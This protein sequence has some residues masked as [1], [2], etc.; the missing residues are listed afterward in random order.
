VTTIATVELPGLGPVMDIHEWLMV[1]P[2]NQWLVSGLIANQSLNMIKAP[3]E[4]G[5]TLIS[6]DFTR[7]Y[8]MGEPEWLGASTKRGI[9]GKSSTW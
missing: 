2:E 4:T 3:R 7:S 9:A 8:V 6:C 5:K 1:V